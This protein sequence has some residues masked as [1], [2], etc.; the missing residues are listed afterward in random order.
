MTISSK[1]STSLI[2]LGK[3][4]VLF[5]CNKIVS[6][7]MKKCLFLKIVDVDVEQIPRASESCLPC[8]F[9]ALSCKKIPKPTQ[10]IR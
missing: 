5:K 9:R 2:I 1:L 10:N 7:K 8:G 6:G 3:Y 4:K